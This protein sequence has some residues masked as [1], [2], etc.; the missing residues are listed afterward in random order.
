MSRAVLIAFV[1]A[2]SGSA[3]APSDA[4]SDAP[5]DA[6]VARTDLVPAVGTD[7][8]VDVACWNL[9]MFPTAAE[10]PRLVGDLIA[11]LAVDVVALEEIESRAALDAMV[12][13]LPGWEVAMP[14]APGSAT[15]GIAL[16]WRTAAATVT[17][18]AVVHAGDPGF[19]RPV[20]RASVETASGRAMIYVVHLKA[21][22]GAADEQTRIDA[23][24][25]LETTVRGEVDATAVDRVLVL[26]D[27]NADF[28]DTRGGEVFAPW[29][30]A[31]ERYSVLTKPLDDA[32]VATFLPASI[33]LDHVIATRAFDPA[34]AAAPIVP[35]LATQLAGYAQTVSDHLP[36]IVQL[37]P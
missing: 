25:K 1:V 24:T 15:G 14:T 37:R 19:V 30:A 3:D 23:M 22:T 35:P 28:D 12:A 6:D 29:T 5:V 21:G 32:D 9:K 27:F 16:A 36:V 34:I 4:P 31:P 17:D 7:G 20:V 13:R 8:T 10:T 11:S 33:T 2:C 18:V 26:G